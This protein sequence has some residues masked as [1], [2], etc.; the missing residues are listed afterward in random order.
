MKLLVALTVFVALSNSSTIPD[1]PKDNSH[2]VDGVSRYIWMP[3]DNGELVLVDLHMTVPESTTLRNDDGNRYWLYTRNNP[4]DYQVLVE[5]DVNILTTSNYNASKP[6]YIVAHGWS[7]GGYS[8][9]GTVLRR[10]FLSAEDCNV[11]VLD[12]GYIAEG[13][14]ISA[15]K[16]APG[17][18]EALGGFVNWLVTKTRGDW[19]SVQFAGCSLGA[20]VIGNAGRVLSGRPARLI[21]LDPAGPLWRT[22]PNKLSSDNG[23]FVEVIHT[24][25]GILGIY[26]PSG[27]IDFYPNGGN[28][29]QPGCTT[30]ACSHNRA[31][32]LLASSVLSKH[33]IGK[34]CNSFLQATSNRCT[35]EELIMGTTDAKK[36]GSGLYGLQTD[37][38]WPF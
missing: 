31:F 37:S 26:N 23:R 19:D 6:T 7:N 3:R 22:N 21:G 28:S 1:I 38:S 15:V 2:Y 5:G 13:L 9:C 14:Y 29:M 20:H 30:S 4:E 8:E 11:I 32:E 17:V 18:G 27:H 12:W 10:A 16:A 36:E 33:F 24:D 25:G 35:G 34:R